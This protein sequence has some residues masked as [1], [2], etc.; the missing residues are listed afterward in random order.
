MSLFD[1]F[2]S[3]KSNDESIP[4]MEP[5]ENAEEELD[6][7]GWRMRMPRSKP[8]AVSFNPLPD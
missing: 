8:S 2:E 7:R 4:N 6:M 3:K 5:D 1:K